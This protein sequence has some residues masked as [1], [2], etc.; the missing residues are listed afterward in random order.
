MKKP[1]SSQSKIKTPAALKRA[2]AKSNRAVF[3]N[4]C[5]DLLHP[6]HV[7]YLEQARA[8]GDTLI[9]A[10]NSDASVSKLKGPGRPVNRLEDRMA[11]LAGLEC[12]D[13]VTWFEHDTPLEL[14]QQLG[15]RIRVLVKG[16]DWKPSQMVG[17]KEVQSWGGQAKS[18]KFVS[19]KSTTAIVE[20]INKKAKLQLKSRP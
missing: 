3:T 17:A 16:G 2:L 20:K 6:G 7:A 19:G 5:F 4:G 18:L 14:I 1:R 8:Q 15:K 13:Y 12:V 9:V 10:L 11:V